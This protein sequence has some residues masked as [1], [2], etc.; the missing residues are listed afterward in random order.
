MGFWLAGT[1]IKMMIEKMKQENHPHLAE[2]RIAALLTDKRKISGNKIVLGTAKKV[3]AEDKVLSD[4]DFKIILSGEDWAQLTE[5]EKFA[6]IDHELSHLDVA[7]VPQTETVGGRKKPVKDEFG[8]TIYTDEIK[9]DDDGKPK[10]KLR[11]HDFENFFHIAER[12]GIEI[13]S[14]VGGYFPPDGEKNQ[15]RAAA[16]AAEP[17]EADEESSE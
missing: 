10:W 7:R 6:L 11:S 16:Q 1:E 17:A 9:Y 4:F 15:A 3:S 5:K 12:Y 2:A 14:K 8:R 13:A